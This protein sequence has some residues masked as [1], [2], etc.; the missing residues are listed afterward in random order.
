ML[1]DTA[2]ADAAVGQYQALV[3]S[4]SE[5]HATTTTTQNA[6]G[7]FGVSLDQAASGASV[8]V[9]RVGTAWV[10]A[11]GAIPVGEPVVLSATAGAVDPASA[12]ASGTVAN[13]I[14]TADSAATAAGDLI[15]VKLA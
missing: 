4:A 2:T 7:F 13:V 11:S 5:G 15:L 1:V 8:P 6:T 14:G 12:L 9:V 3:Y 10:T